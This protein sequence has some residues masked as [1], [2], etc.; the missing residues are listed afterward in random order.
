M[1][2]ALFFEEKFLYQNSPVDENTNYKVIRPVVW[3][4]QE[5]YIQDILGT[6]LYKLIKDEIET[7][8]GTL[9]TARLLTL[10]NDYVAPCLLNYVLMDS[11]MTMLFKMRNKSVSTDRS[12]YSNPVEY[13]TYLHL[14]DEYQLKAEQY[15]EKIQRY[16]CANSSTYPEYT[17]YSTSD[18]VR[19]QNQRPDIG[20][21]LG[22]LNIPKDYGYEYY[23]KG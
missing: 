11:Q 12:D 1:S 22:G 17:N 18:E 3:D 4:C 16:L 19:A 10:V 2:R 21:Y 6:P 8:G 15:A 5:L 14:K 20:I 9:T 7:N 23:E 13:K